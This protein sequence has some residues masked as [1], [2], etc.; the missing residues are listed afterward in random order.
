MK[1]S[2][3]LVKREDLIPKLNILL[4]ASSGAGRKCQGLFYRISIF[5]D[6][7]DNYLLFDSCPFA[8]FGCGKRLAVP[9]EP[10]C[11]PLI[12]SLLCHYLP[13]H[14]VR[15]IVA[16][17]IYSANR[18]FWS[19]CWPDIGIEGFKGITPSLTDCDSSSSIVFPLRVRSSWIMASADDPEPCA[20][21]LGM[22]KTV[23]PM[24][25]FVF[26]TSATLRMTGSNLVG[27]NL[28]EVA[29]FTPAKAP[30]FSVSFLRWCRNV[31]QKCKSASSRLGKWSRIGWH[32]DLHERLACWPRRDPFSMR[33][34]Y[35]SVSSLGDQ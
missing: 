6:S 23:R 21:L 7:P 19:W 18:V 24:V 14:V 1:S 26:D 22:R 10:S 8:P 3:P 12:S 15:F 33:P 5:V 32:V 25:S 13:L 31:M 4:G 34:L 27:P 2:G 35:F 29:T 11:R 28:T 17:V 16:V 30:S 9:R 20:P